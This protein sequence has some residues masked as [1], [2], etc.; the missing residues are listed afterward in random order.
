M[1]FITI[2]EH[3][4]Y[5]K[6]ADATWAALS[7]EAPYLG[8]A[9]PAGLPYHVPSDTLKERIADMDAGG[10]DLQVLSYAAY[11]QL[12]PADEAVLAA[13]AANDDLAEMI[14]QYPNR[15]SGFAT[16]PWSDPDAAAKELART[17][18]TLNL[19]GALIAGRPSP[20]ALF[21]DDLAYQPV[22]EMATAL[23]VPI[24]IHPGYPVPAVRESYYSG[25]SDLVSDRLS[26]FG[27]GWHAEAGI[28]ILRM[29]LSGVFD[30]N[31][32]LQLIAGHWGEMIP[33]FLSRLDEALPQEATGLPHTIS[34]YFVSHVYV[35]PSGMFDWPHF[36][37]ILQVM[38]ADRVIYSV[39]YPYINN[40][41]AVSFL[42]EAPI[43]QLEKEKISHL[44]AEKLL[45][46]HS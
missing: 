9:S 35:T 15:L 12:L 7:K 37:F 27:W 21:L 18:K 32:N 17:V 19:K 6:L 29:I 26:L 46:L 34:K 28:Q 36:Q 41:K 43:S 40:D 11:P 38:G 39:D 20:E 10:I 23:N 44:N 45:S 1:K 13:K 25:L 22:L 4:H 30:R 14:R 3:V 16:L 5:S 24:Y 33:F 8:K 42:Q 2:E 31:P